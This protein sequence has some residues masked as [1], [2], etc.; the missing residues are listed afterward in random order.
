MWKTRKKKLQRSNTLSPCTMQTRNNMS[1]NGVKRTSICANISY[2][3]VSCARQKWLI[4]RALALTP[5]VFVQCS[6]IL[7]FLSAFHIQCTQLY[8]DPNNN[9]HF[10]G[11]SLCLT[12]IGPYVTQINVL[13]RVIVPR[14]AAS[15]TL[16]VLP[17]GWWWWWWCQSFANQNSDTRICYALHALLFREKT[18]SHTT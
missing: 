18:H 6:T 4:V 8:T 7:F 15:C 16:K 1:H 2:G 10:T 17:P 11:L 13:M 9:S 14:G 3:G 12:S 5:F